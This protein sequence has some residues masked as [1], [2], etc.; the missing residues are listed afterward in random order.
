[1]P[2][3]SHRINLDMLRLMPPD[4]RVVLEVGCLAGTLAE[5]YRR[6]NPE[7]RY[8]GIARDSE[9]A[10]AA[11]S[12]GG[13]DRVVIGDAGV[14]EPAALGLPEPGTENPPVV[15]C[16]VIG[17]VLEHMVDPWGVLARLSRWVRDGGQVLACIPN[18]QHYSVVVNL[19]RGQWEYQ[20]E[21]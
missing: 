2:D 5:A 15:D 7:V 12:A 3:M 17:D 4:A 14:I 8:L 13:L 6:I 20:E 11:E 10:R 9:A 19:L 16:L 18:V 1:L 21:G